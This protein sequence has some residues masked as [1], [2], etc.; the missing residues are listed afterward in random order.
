M[1][2]KKVKSLS[3]SKLSSLIGGSRPGG[4][5]DSQDVTSELASGGT[6]T[7]TDN[8]GSDNQDVTSEL[9]SGGTTTDT[10]R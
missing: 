3:T 8:T 4:S 5:N 1:K 9:A 10:E 6:T 7:D 2:I